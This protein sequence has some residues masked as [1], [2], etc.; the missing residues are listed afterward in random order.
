MSDE[1]VLYTVNGESEYLMLDSLRSSFLECS[2]SVFL[3]VSHRSCWHVLTFNQERL[4]E[5]V[6]SN[7]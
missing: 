3:C 5:F 1:M 7:T 4:I 2:L 6:S